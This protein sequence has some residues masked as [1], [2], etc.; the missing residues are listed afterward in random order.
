MIPDPARV[1][2]LLREAAA[3]IVMPRWRALERHEVMTKQRGD[4]V[5][6]ADL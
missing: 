1:T 6:V 2:A 3:E 4:V 5:T